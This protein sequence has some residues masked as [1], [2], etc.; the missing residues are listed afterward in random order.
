MNNYIYAYYQQI[1]D[2]TVRVGQWIR[3]IY[4]IIIR[5]LD[6]KSFFYSHK[7]A[8]AAILF[9]ENFCHHHEGELAPD[10]IKL[11]LWQK[12]FLSILFG[13]LDADGHRH[14]REVFFVVARKNGKTLLAAAIAA[15]C[16]FL[17]GEYGGRIYFAAPKLE[18]ANL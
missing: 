14:F 17:D 12:A 7:K 8:Q 9:I 2:G 6:N 1:V 5:G 15:Y 3:M 11:E 4:E 10:K 16:T 18:Q 13:I